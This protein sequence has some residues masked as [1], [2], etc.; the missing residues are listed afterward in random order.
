M[1]LQAASLPV[2]QNAR[3]VQNAYVVNDL[4]EACRRWHGVYGVGPFIGSRRFVLEMDYRGRRVDVEMAGAFAQSGDVV[5]ELLQQLNDVPSP[6]R[7]LFPQ[8]REGFHHVAAFCDDYAETRARAQAA[9]FEIAG[10]LDYAPGCRICYIDTSAVLGHMV[11]LYTDHPAVR[12]LYA[13]VRAASQDWD[14][15]ELLKLS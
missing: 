4:E 12:D 2:L 15:A 1:S 14:G 3:I 6:F 11:E 13:A 10:E 7:Q 8:G 5:L 9:G